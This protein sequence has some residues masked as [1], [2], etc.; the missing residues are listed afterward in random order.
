MLHTLPEWNALRH[1]A[2]QMRDV[3]MRSLFESDPRRFFSFSFC[4]NDMVV[5]FSK[6]RVRGR[7]MEL[8]YALAQ[9]RG[10]AERARQMFSGAAI[11]TTERRAVLHVALR[12]AA[13]RPFFVDGA[14]V[15]P[16][17]LHELQSMARFV[18]GVRDGRI[19]S[20]SGERFTHVV[21]IGIGGSD[22]G[23]KMVCESLAP[24]ADG[25]QAR[26]VSNVD[27]S[28]FLQEVAGLNPATTLFLVASKTF[29]TQETMANA[30]TARAWIVESLGESAVPHHFVA[31]STNLPKVQQ[32]G[33]MPERTFGFWDWVGGRYSLWSVIGMSIALSC[34]MSV[35]GQLL[36]GASLADEHFLGAPPEQ[37]IPLTM[38]LLGF[39][40]GEFFDS[41]AHAVLPYDHY[42]RSFPAFLQQLDME[43]NGK[44]VRVDGSRVDYRTGPVIFGE[45]GTNGQHAFYQLLHQGTQCIPADIL[46][47]AESHNE[48]GSHHAIL[49]ANALAQ[50]EA[51]MRGKTES[52]VRAE[53]ASAGV[54]AESVNDIIPHRVFDGNRPSTVF[55]L[56]RLTP[57]CLGTLIALYEHKVFAQGVLWNINS[58]DQ[59]GV[60]LGKQLAGPILSELSGG[61]SSPHDG[62]TAELIRI[63]R[64]MRAGTV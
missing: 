47:A 51:F 57:S 58:F 36:E 45:P 20:A 17:I 1:E 16:A 43:S 3:H 37:N 6:H 18:E 14:D 13:K 10:V 42:L 33:I 7:T 2:E 61:A 34:G 59:W 38:A 26:F 19:A 30:N 23:P 4:L 31:L 8:L 44:S 22:L 54:N 28:N 9:A 39:W 24:Y 27:A 49:V 52:E 12:N 63:A 46:V 41:H 11:N 32:F 62:S 48:V 15:S 56:R 21:N 5:D 40:Y 60:E 29:T 55:L 53:Y 25:P 35:F 64:S 50:A